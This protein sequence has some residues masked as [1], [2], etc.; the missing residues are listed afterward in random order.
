MDHNAASFPAYRT[1]SFLQTIR[2][3]FVEVATMLFGNATFEPQ[4]SL[5]AEARELV[6]PH[7]AI[8]VHKRCRLLTPDANGAVQNDR[9]AAELSGFVERCFFWPA[10]AANETHSRVDRRHLV[11]LVDRIVDEEQ[12]RLAAQNCSLPQTSRFDSYWAD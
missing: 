2:G 8:L 4:R 10:P 11:K 1:S 9:W 5:D 6:G 7:L 12:S 3:A